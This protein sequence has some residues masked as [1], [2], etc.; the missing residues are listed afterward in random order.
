MDA[1]GF[2]RAD[3]LSGLE[4]PKDPFWSGQIVRLIIRVNNKQRTKMQLRIF[5]VFFFGE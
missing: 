2:F 4:R 3:K 1:N 5:R